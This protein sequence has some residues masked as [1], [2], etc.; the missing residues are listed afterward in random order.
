MFRSAL[1]IFA[2]A[3]AAAGIAGQIVLI[4]MLHDWSRDFTKRRK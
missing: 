2:V 1:V 4:W 3:C